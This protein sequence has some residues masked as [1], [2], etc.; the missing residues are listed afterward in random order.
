MKRATKRVIHSTNVVDINR[1]TGEVIRDRFETVSRV[2]SEPDFIKL[3]LQDISHLLDLPKAPSGLLMLLI[4]T[5]DYEGMIM[6]ST[7]GRKRMA[8]RLG[9]SDGSFRNYL[10]LLV[11]K[12]L[13]IR[14]A[15]NDYEANPN[16]FARG[17]WSEIYERRKRLE[18]TV[19][20]DERG[21]TIKARAVTDAEEEQLQLNI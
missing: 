16:Y 15:N 20:Y 2:P 11:K 17:S 18:L 21:R 10:S 1:E 6:L 5:M 19:S 13:L 4:Q 8:K 9:I 3:Y 12:G 14:H 7:A